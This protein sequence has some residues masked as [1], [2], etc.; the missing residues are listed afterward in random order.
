MFF[1]DEPSQ[2]LMEDRMQS[3]KKEP[4]QSLKNPTKPIREKSLQF[5]KKEHLK[6]F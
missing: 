4:S 3:L 1:Y 2:S 6:S 5:F